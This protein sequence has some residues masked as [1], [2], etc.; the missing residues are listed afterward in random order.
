MNYTV[1]I[2]SLGKVCNQ[3]HFADKRDAL[4]CARLWARSVDAKETQPNHWTRRDFT[5]EVTL[6]PYE[7]ATP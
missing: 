3:K 6:T 1:T 5:Y 2:L 7:E 4:E